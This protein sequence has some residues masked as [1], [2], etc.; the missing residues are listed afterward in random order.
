MARRVADAALMLDV[1]AGPDPNDPTALG[2]PPPRAFMQL[3]RGVRGLRI[4]VD[5]DYALKGIDAGQA[6][7]IESAFGVLQSLG[8]RIVEVKMPDVSHVVDIWQPICGHEMAAAHAATFPTRAT[9]YGPYLR[10][11]LQGGLRVTPDE[12]AAASRARQMLTQQLNLVLDSVDAVAGPAGGDPAWPITHAIQVGPLPAYHAAWSAA[13]P[14][15]AEFTMPM[16]LAGVPA[17]CLPSGFSPDG[18]PYSI[19]FTAR[20]LSEAV[21]GSIAYAYETA[22]PWHVRHPVDPGQS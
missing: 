17:I 21:L 1:I 12:L 9:E 6:K 18:L 10:E 14:R 7:A 19:Q 15:S 20:R 16:D 8:A 11:F 5:R 13:A 4:G 3:R 22:T 2:V